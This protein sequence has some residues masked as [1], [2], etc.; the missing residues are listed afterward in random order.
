M[1]DKLIIST[2]IPK[3]GGT[4][5]RKILEINY[6]D[7]LLSEYGYKH[8][9]YKRYLDFDVSS[10]ESLTQQGIDCLHG[11]FK[12]RKYKD[13]DAKFITWVRDPFELIPSSFYFIKKNFP[14]HKRLPNKD[15][16]LLE[17]IQHP[18]NQNVMSNHIDGVGFERL[19]FVGVLEEFEKS[20]NLLS[21]LINIKPIERKIEVNVNKDKGSGYQLSEEEFD[22]IERLNNPDL[23]LYAKSLKKVLSSNGS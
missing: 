13:F 1:K 16:S 10:A 2:H 20:M 15:C 3:V 22:E 4:S 14:D 12:L 9:S 6:G 11:H 19:S 17:F 5:F 21:T 18:L 23:K 8:P 7:R